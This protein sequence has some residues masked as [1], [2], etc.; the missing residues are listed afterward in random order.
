MT[1]DEHREMAEMYLEKHENLSEQVLNYDYL[2][3]SLARSLL[4]ILASVM[5]GD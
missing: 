1:R 4:G 5:K 2:L 3:L